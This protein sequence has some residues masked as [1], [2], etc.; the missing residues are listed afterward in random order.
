MATAQQWTLCKIHQFCE[1]D[2]LRFCLKM[3]LSVTWG[4]KHTSNLWNSYNLPFST[5]GA[6]IQQTNKRT[7]REIDGQH[8]CLLQAPEWRPYNNANST[9]PSH[10]KLLLCNWTAFNM[11]SRGL[12]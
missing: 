1:L 10:S 2:L 11:D 9:N 6:Q 12:L 5:I 7:D 3:V 4:G 8:Q